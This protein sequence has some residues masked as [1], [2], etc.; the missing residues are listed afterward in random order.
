MA[1]FSVVT[2]FFHCMDVKCIIN[3]TGM[4]VSVKLSAH[5]NMVTVQTC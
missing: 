3:K 4:T 2:L 5:L 1:A